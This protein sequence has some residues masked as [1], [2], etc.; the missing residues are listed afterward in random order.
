MTAILTK[1]T[2][3]IVAENLLV[4]EDLRQATCELFP[5]ASLIVVHTPNDA[6]AKLDAALLV[7]VAVIAISS[8]KFAAS[9]LACRLA[10]DNTRIVLTGPWDD[11]SVRDKGWGVLPFPFITQDVQA[12]LAHTVT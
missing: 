9:P 6:L 10:K 12:M 3:L 5:N 2:Y 4:A 11:A 7:D 1:T 8:Q